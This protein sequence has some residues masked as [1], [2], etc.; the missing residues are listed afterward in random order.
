MIHASDPLPNESNLDL[1]QLDRLVDGELSDD[2]RRAVVEQLESAPGGWRRCALAFMEA[3]CW[4]Q[5]LRTALEEPATVPALTGA[6]SSG[7]AQPTTASREHFRATFGQNLWEQGLMLAASFMVAFTLGIAARSWLTFSPPPGN[8]QMAVTPSQA[9]GPGLE[10]ELLAAGSGSSAEGLVA[11][12]APR[13]V[14]LK[15]AGQDAESA[16]IPL[17]V[18]GVDDL[19]RQWLDGDDPLPSEWVKQLARQGLRLE[20]VRDL[21]PMRLNDGTPAE[22]PVERWQ[23]RYV[24]NDYQ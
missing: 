21:A 20:R 7:A 15:F 19:A 2:Q 11:D 13:Q 6:A 17:P 14:V 18:L 12:N 3:Q 22:V 9:A 10:N 16:G 4:R 24:G 8:S 5:G 23:I 1:A